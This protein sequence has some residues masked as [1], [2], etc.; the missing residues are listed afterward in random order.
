[1]PPWYHQTPTDDDCNRPGG[2]DYA[3]FRNQNWPT[4]DLFLEPDS[5]DS[6]E[7]F[8]KNKSLE[9][10][11]RALD[12]LEFGELPP[13]VI[14]RILYNVA[15]TEKMVELAIGQTGKETLQAEAAEAKIAAGLK[16][17]DK[18]TRLFQ[19]AKR[20]SLLK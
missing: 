3:L 20:F 1:M 9:L 11:P 18:T 7:S 5:R 10:W 15:L 17:I 8:Y 13:Q 14:R 2:N 16:L 6:E 19:E 12:F 4:T